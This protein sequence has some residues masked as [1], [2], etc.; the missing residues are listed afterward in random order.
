MVAY[1]REYNKRKYRDINLQFDRVK[2]KDVLDCLDS[3]PSKKQFIADL[4]RKYMEDQK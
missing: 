1:K 4:V 3:F 2:D